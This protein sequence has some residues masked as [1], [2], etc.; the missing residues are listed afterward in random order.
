MELEKDP[1]QDIR[2]QDLFYTTAHKHHTGSFSPSNTWAHK[3][4]PEG[5]SDIKNL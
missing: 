3:T 1:R 5:N 4:N 2:K